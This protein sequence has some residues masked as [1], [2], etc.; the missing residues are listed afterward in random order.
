MSTTASPPGPTG[1]EGTLGVLQTGG[2]LGPT[3][4]TP[5]CGDGHPRE[6]TIKAPATPKVITQAR[7][8]RNFV[9]SARSSWANPSRPIELF[10]AVRRHGG[11]HRSTSTTSLGWN[12]TWSLVSS[13]YAAS[14]LA[15]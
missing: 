12:S 4:Q 9:N 2:D 7:T 8:V 13:M 5:V 11:C 14:K 1:T 10:G 15:W 3:T 6:P